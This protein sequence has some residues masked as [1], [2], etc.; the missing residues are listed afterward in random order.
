M[1]LADTA[2]AD[3]VDAWI[4]DNWSTDLELGEW[5]RRLFDA[6]YSFP[7][8]PAGLGGFGASPTQ[9]HT[10]TSRLASAGVIGPPTGNGPNMG[11]PTLLRHATVEQRQRFVPP[12]ARGETQ[13]CQLFSEPGAGSDLASLA[14]RADVDGDQFVISG[15]KVWNSRADVSEVGMLLCRTDPAQPKHRGLT[16]VMIDMLQPG[17]EVRP[18]VQM[19]GASE[20]CEVFLSDAR[21]RLVDVIGTVGDGW[22]VAR[23]T[24]THERASAAAGKRRGLVSVDAGAMSGNLG[25]PVGEL[26]EE[27]RRAAEDPRRRWELLLNSRTMISL[28]EQ[29]GVLDQPALRDRLM[30]YYVHGEVY[31]LNGQRARDWAKSGRPAPDG[32]MMKLDLARLAHESRDLSLS[33]VG[34]EGMLA[35][36]DAR[37]HGRVQRAALSSF[38][39]S[40]GGG[41]NEIQRNILGERNLGLPRE[42]GSD[43]DVPFKDLRRS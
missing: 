7:T 42:P 8:W 17:V 26:I 36:A 25:R 3:T 37:Q 11:G 1:V 16:F 39:P 41:T 43:N 38:V 14:T 12:M 28:A 6:G 2:L 40:L 5:W 19:N 30:R 10:V 21:A 24:L 34:A 15:Q 33:L 27:S 13:W 9:A 18:L 20:F 35:G 22:N 32:S 31:R 4:D 23:T 29:S